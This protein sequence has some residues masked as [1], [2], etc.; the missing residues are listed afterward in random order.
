MFDASS[1][2]AGPTLNN[3]LYFSPDLLSE[4]FLILLRPRFNFFA[5][6]ADIKQ[7]FLNV[8]IPKEHRDLLCFLWSENV[9]SESDV[10]LIVYRF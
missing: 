7:A 3:G 5:V 1:A 6:L 8:K 2:L 4:I 10:K 9:D